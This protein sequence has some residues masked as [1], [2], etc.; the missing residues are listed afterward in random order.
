MY[1]AT[2]NVRGRPLRWAFHWGKSSE[3]PVISVKLRGSAPFAKVHVIK[4]G[5]GSFDHA[6]FQID[7]ESGIV[8]D[9]LEPDP[10]WRA[11]SAIAPASMHATSTAEER[12][13]W[14]CP[15]AEIPGGR[16]E[17]WCLP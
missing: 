4:D 11:T 13:G 6:L 9:T 2:D 15:E 3:P 1:Q 17:R 16:D 12:S 5:G 8:D 10:Y 7:N 14:P